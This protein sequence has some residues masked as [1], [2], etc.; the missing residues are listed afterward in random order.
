[1]NAKRILPL[2]GIILAAIFMA[3]ACDTYEPPAASVTGM[4]HTDLSGASTTAN[5]VI[6]YVVLDND[7]DYSNGYSQR[8]AISVANPIQG[9][10]D[11]VEGVPYY[12][13][14][15]PAGS[16]YLYAIIDTDGDGI[17]TM[18]TDYQDAYGYYGGYTS[19]TYQTYVPTSSANLTLG[20]QG[21]YTCDF[22]VYIPSAHG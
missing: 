3:A 11:S 18:S 17:Y 20:T 21:Y 2:S 4:L 1:M 19:P 5:P 16:Y 9:A 8:V 15:V 12:F 7:A 10:L 14:T 13:E 22:W 6:G